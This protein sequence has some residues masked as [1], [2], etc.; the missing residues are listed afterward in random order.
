MGSGF[1]CLS[2]DLE[3]G[4]HNGQQ[5]H[6]QHPSKAPTHSIHNRSVN[7]IGRKEEYVVCLDVSIFAL[8]QCL[9]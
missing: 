8:I 6:F 5:G 4:E 3:I 7:L 9:E 2:I 1:S